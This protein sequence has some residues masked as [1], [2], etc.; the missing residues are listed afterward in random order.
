MA[1]W[2]SAGVDEDSKLD[3]GDAQKVVKRTAAL[4]RPYR[5]L[6]IRAGTLLVVWTGLLVTLPV[7]FGKAIDA[8]DRGDSAVLNRSIVAYVVIAVANYFLW[9]SAIISLARAGE[10][11]LRDLRRRVFDKLLNLSMPFYDREKAGVIVSRMT[12]DIDSLAELVQFGLQMFLSN[13]L[14]LFGV[15]IVLAIL[16]WQL[17]LV[18]L[19]SVPLVTIASRKFQRDSN[20]AYLR[21]R[22]GIGA[23]LSSLQEGLA[24]VRVIQSYSRTKIESERFHATNYSL[25]RSHMNSTR[26]AAWYLPVVD[27]AGITTTAVALGIG[28]WMVNDG[29]LSLGTVVTFVLLLQNLF[30][31]V[32]QLS[33]LFNMVQSAAAGL[34]KLYS[35][36][37]EEIEVPEAVAPVELPSRADV[38]VTGVGF[39]YATGPPV[40]R[41][42]DLH[43]GMGERL[44]LVGPTGAGKSTLAKLIARL[45]DPTEGSIEYGGIDLRLAS[46]ASLRDRIIVVPQEGHIFDGTVRDNIR[47]ARA[48]ATDEEIDDALHRIGVHHRFVALPEGIDTE[49]RERG[50]RLSAGERQLVSLARAALVDPGVLILDEATSSLD[51]GTEAVV[52]AAMDVLMTDRTTIVIAHRLSTAA[53]CDRVGVV[54]A[55]MLAELGTHDDL[56]GLGGRY[57]ALFAAWQG[58]QE[59]IG[60]TGP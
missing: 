11:F 45:Y 43:I 21:V 59:P 2:M 32:Q 49:V 5:A 26:I 35:L 6:V 10:K 31:P 17:F 52:E 30:E 53:R 44:A 41:G 54:D 42:V 51:P 48:S 33:Q 1:G 28:G 4:L 58:A 60:S 3:K 20:D 40:L 24:G 57:T 55:G 14:L 27:L 36:L 12:S 18:C 7:L 39:S 8:I 34:N 38:L 23:T 15:A 19:V 56:V 46:R 16:S 47:V 50:S 9:R 25:F 13:I 22:D 37:D 29:R